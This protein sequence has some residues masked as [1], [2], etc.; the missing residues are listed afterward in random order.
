MSKALRLSLVVHVPLNLISILDLWR[1]VRGRAQ[2]AE[3]DDASSS[4]LTPK[5]ISYRGT[6]RL[7]AGDECRVVL[8]HEKEEEEGRGEGLVARADRGSG[9]LGIRWR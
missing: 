5:R 6:S 3:D 8:E 7:H 2:P 1:D 9:G 4:L